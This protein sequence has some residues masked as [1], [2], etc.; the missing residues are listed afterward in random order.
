MSN[1]IQSQAQTVRLICPI[2][3]EDTVMGMDLA[4]GGHLTHGAPVS[5]S[6]VKPTTLFLIVLILKRNS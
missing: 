3:P 4:S 5:F 6:L 1:H 2:E